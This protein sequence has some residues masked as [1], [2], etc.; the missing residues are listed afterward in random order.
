[1]IN[2]DLSKK[3]H[4]MFREK[5]LVLSYLNF[6]ARKFTHSARKFKLAKETPCIRL[7]KSVCEPVSVCT[8]T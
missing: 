2:E 8:S 7:Y 3:N 5:Y 4:H 6:P 1:M